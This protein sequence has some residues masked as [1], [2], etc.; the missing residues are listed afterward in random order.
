[1]ASA[2][3]SPGAATRA[4]P[5]I[6]AAQTY[7]NMGP[8]HRDNLIRYAYYI[9]EAPGMVGMKLADWH[10][11]RSAIRMLAA[12]LGAYFAANVI[13]LPGAYSAVITTLI[14]ARPHSC[15][16]L[17]ACSVRMTATMLGAG[18]TKTTTKRQK[19]HKPEKQK[20]ALT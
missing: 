8:R 20:I 10:E 7:L 4:A 14:V 9:R 2:A 6:R 3:S 5:V 13:Q 17:R 15:G 16:V 12:A 1:M 11:G 18:N 19:K